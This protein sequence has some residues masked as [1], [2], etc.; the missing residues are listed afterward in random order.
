MFRSRHE[1]QPKAL[2]SC[3]HILCN[4]TVDATALK[5]HSRY[6]SE[7]RSQR[8]P[9]KANT[10]GKPPRWRPAQSWRT[11]CRRSRRPRWSR[12]PRPGRRRSALRRGSRP[13]GPRGGRSPRISDLH[14]ERC[15]EVR[16]LAARISWNPTKASGISFWGVGVRGTRRQGAL[17]TVSGAS[18]LASPRGA[19]NLGVA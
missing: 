1:F 16:Q 15:G 2:A 19:S 4:H 9:E 7:P 5:H 11:S 10:C 8:A 14:A 18:S 6:R 3:V 17:P 13:V 12:S